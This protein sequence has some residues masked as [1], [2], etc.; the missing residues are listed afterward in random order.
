MDT[1]SM[2]RFHV[3]SVHVTCCTTQT[4]ETTLLTRHVQTDYD[5]QSDKTTQ[6]SDDLQINPCNQ[7]GKTLTFKLLI[8]DHMK[9]CHNN[10]TSRKPIHLTS[11]SINPFPVGFPSLTNPFPYPPMSSFG[12][13]Q[14]KCDYCGWLT[15]CGRELKKH[16]INLHGCPSD[17]I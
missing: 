15:S 16:K 7:C 10:L 17:G 4:E 8:I 5:P 2:L 6:T 13:L 11:S 14:L 12:P 1:V 9:S 3:Q